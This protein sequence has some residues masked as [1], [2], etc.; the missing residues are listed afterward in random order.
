MKN[1]HPHN[2][3]WWALVVQGVGLLF[4]APFAWFLKDKFAAGSLL[5][6]GSACLIPNIYLYHRVFRHFGAQNA[7]KMVK[8]LYFG[9]VVKLILTGVIFG[10]SLTIAWIKPL[11]LFMGYLF[12]Q[13][14]F[15]VAPLMW[16]VRK[17]NKE[18]RKNYD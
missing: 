3:A 1:K 10:L 9:E 17:Q 8:A 4:V 16:S 6:G 7:H 18:V 14:I 11:F 5:F 2:E 15:W 13:V 12:A